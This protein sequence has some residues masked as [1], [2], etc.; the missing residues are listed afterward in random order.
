MRP[1]PR[2][3]SF[4]DLTFFARFALRILGPVHF[5][6]GGKITFITFAIHIIIKGGTAIVDRFF[7]N[8]I[9]RLK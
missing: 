8:T 9:A 2:Y 3:F 6:L 4:F 1:S 5:E 7:N